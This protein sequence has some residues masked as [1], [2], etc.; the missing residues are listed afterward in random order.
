MTE[1]SLD[2]ILE[3]FRALALRFGRIAEDAQALSDSILDDDA[4]KS[5]PKVE[6]WGNDAGL[7]ARDL[8]EAIGVI[9]REV[10][11]PTSSPKDSDEVDETAITAVLSLDEVA[12]EP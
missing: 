7:L 2:V 4:A 1:T 6:Q 11:P 12:D 5:S 9:H 8:A 3:G 10:G